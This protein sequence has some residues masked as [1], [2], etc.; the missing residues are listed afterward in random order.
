MKYA[1]QHPSVRL[2]L[3]VA[4]LL[5]V[6]GCSADNEDRISALETE[7]LSLKEYNAAHREELAQVR[8]NL[9]AIHDLL[10][11]DRGR[12]RLKEGKEP[13]MDSDKDLDAKAKDFVDKN[14]NRL[15]EL[16]KKLLDKMEKELDERF[17]KMDE[18]APP[19]GDRI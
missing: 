8:K 18:P 2:V 16:T 9:E 1:R 4:L 5:A 11:L 19:Q 13:E 3:A 10:E 15:L 6:M 12:A 7:V 17:K 14:L